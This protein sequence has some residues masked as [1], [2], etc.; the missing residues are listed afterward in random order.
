MNI[1]VINRNA[2]GQD[3]VVE[4]FKHLGHKVF[5]YD[6]KDITEHRNAEIE[7]E[8]LE[9]VNKEDISLIFSYN[10]VPVVS[11]AIKDTKVKY[12]SYVYDSPNI[13]LYTYSIIYGNVFYDCI[14]VSVAGKYIPFK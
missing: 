3:D 7:K 4:I 10:Y 8:L 9:F 2:F 6:H 5:V 1:L 11:I 14:S 13:A 12:I